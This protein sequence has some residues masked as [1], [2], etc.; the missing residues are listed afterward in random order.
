MG[1]CSNCGAL[2]GAGLTVCAA[3]GATLASRPATGGIS[4]TKG[5]SSADNAAD[6][7]PGGAT[8]VSPLDT[9]ASWNSAPPTTPAPPPTPAPAPDP[10]GAGSPAAPAQPVADASFSSWNTPAP[11]QPMSNGLPSYAQPA[12]VST[13]PVHAPATGAGNALESK[14]GLLAGILAA[15]AALCLIATRTSWSSFSWVT[16]QLSGGGNSFPPGVRDLFGLLSFPVAIALCVYAALAV[17]KQL[18]SRRWLLLAAAVFVLFMDFGPEYS[19]TLPEVTLARLLVVG[20]LV[21]TVLMP[22]GARPAGARPASVETA[23]QVLL[24]VNLALTVV[25]VMALLGVGHLG[26]M[27]SAG[28]FTALLTWTSVAFGWLGRRKIKAGGQRDGRIFV[29]AAA[30]ASLVAGAFAST[31]SMSGAAIDFG[32]AYAIVAGV[33]LWV[34][35]GSRA[36]FGDARTELIPTPSWLKRPPALTGVPGLGHPATPNPGPAAFAAPGTVAPPQSA[37]GGAPGDPYA[38]AAAGHAVPGADSSADWYSALT[39]GGWTRGLIA[40]AIC[41][42]IAIGGAI[43]GRIS[44]ALLIDAVITVW[45]IGVVFARAWIPSVSSVTVSVPSAVMNILRPSGGM[46]V[47]QSPR[48]G[49]DRR[50]RTAG[51]VAAPLVVGMVGALIIGGRTTDY[52]TVCA[53]RDTLQAQLLTV[54][55]VFD[56]GVF[57]AMR[58]LGEDASAFDGKG[59]P[60]SVTDSVHSAGDSLQSLADKGSAYVYEVN[61]AMAPITSM[62][63]GSYMGGE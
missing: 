13:P 52:A 20:V 16:N 4:L 9:F 35:P 34:A 41:V 26:S 50:Y 33:L 17:R 55:G 37:I 36:W 12:G 14:S 53:S 19:G 63:T 58:S 47:D 8:Q 44:T 6:P 38:A 27:G 24:V 23:V 18:N 42:A 3:C 7:W 61:S 59:Q 1:R 32:L 15:A 54:N 45:L 51:I 25:G 43:S 21:A 10:W 56:N 11:A 31:G 29:S 49:P 5:P 48:V 39:N 40:G 30:G 46:T 28:I 22:E 57:D 60:S 2:H 62:C